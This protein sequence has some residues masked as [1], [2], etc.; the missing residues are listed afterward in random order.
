M[1][2]GEEFSDPKVRESDWATCLASKSPP[3]FEVPPDTE[4]KKTYHT[5][6]TLLHIG[7]TYRYFAFILNDCKIL[8]PGTRDAIRSI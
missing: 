3:S 4:A 7:L 1:L 2:G 8:V 6:Y 5:S